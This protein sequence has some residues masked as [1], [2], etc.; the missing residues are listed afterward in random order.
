MAQTTGAQAIIDAVIT[1][2]PIF[3]RTSKPST[4]SLAG[5]LVLNNIKLHD[6]PVAV[7]VLNDTTVLHG[8]SQAIRTKIIPCWVQGN[9]YR[10]LDP[11]AHF[12]QGEI[13]A[14]IKAPSLLD[15]DGKI[16]SRGHP[17]YEEYD[18]SDFVSAR[19]HGAKGD[20]VTD[21][22]AALQS[23]LDKVSGSVFYTDMFTFLRTL[24][25][26]T[27]QRRLFSSTRDFIS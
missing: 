23:L 16:V 14:P 12:T 24:F 27:Q 19:D 6:V 15:Q 10:S 9:T 25:D 1:N 4:G 11:R 21:D 8:T 5:S 7:G 2:T 18:V 20:G 26:S 13:S 17:Q 22:T 3:I